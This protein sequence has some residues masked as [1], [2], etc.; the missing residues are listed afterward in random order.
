MEPSI[1][2]SAI[3]AIEEDYVAADFRRGDL[4]LFR[5][6]NNN[7][8]FLFKRVIG[9]PNEA[10]SITNGIVYV[11]LQPLDEPYIA[12]IP[13]YSGNWQVPAGEVFVLSDN[14]NLGSD[15]HN[16]GP[17]PMD[18]II[19]KGV[20]TCLGQFRLSCVNAIEPIIYEKFE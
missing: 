17:L 3:V 1:N 14:R 12:E 16:W 8:V 7:Q 5:H 19:G 4:V 20:A 18:L 10:I 9:L 13:T 15:S 2:S 6:P 11:N